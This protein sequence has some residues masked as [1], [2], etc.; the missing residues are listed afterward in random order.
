M[1]SSYQIVNLSEED[2][3]HDLDSIL[4][5]HRT[6]CWC[7]YA[8]N[9]PNWAI[10]RLSFLLGWTRPGI[11]CRIYKARKDYVRWDLKW[12]G[13]EGQIKRNVCCSTISCREGNR[14]AEIMCHPSY[15]I[16]V[17][18][19]HDFNIQIQPRLFIVILRSKCDWFRLSRYGLL[20]AT[21]VYII[22]RETSLGS[23][24]EGV[25]RQKE[26]YP[27]G[28]FGVKRGHPKDHRPPTLNGGILIRTKTDP[29]KKRKRQTIWSPRKQKRKRKITVA[30]RHPLLSSS[31]DT[32]H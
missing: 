17:L 1:I 12:V 16:N 2:T 20:R 21:Y 24:R 13:Q 23:L 9:G 11:L 8:R 15:G 19:R 25:E 31:K 3:E 29:R 30:T 18:G 4:W 10:F 5:M 27:G 32:K 7:L 14:H 28:R 26:R 6:R 22:Y